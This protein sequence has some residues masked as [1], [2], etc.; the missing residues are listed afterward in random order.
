MF[1]QQIRS[2]CPISGRLLENSKK[3]NMNWMRMFVNG[4]T[5]MIVSNVM[6][7]ISFSRD[8]PRCRAPQ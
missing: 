4:V 6:P 3:G 5:F 2:D 7:D 1:E 8:L